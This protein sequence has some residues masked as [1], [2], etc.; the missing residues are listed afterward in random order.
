[1][2]K[3]HFVPIKNVEQELDEQ[4]VHRVV[5]PVLESCSLFHKSLS[6]HV[7]GKQNELDVRLECCLQGRA[8]FRPSHLLS[9][10][11]Q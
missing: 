10:I 6:I 7:L 8:G 4:V 9:R 5:H 11:I 1:M 3:L 2:V